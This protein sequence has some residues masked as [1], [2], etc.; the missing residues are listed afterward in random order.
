MTILQLIQKPQLRGA[1]MFACQLSNE[2]G[3]LGHKVLIVSLFPGESQ[4][5]INGIFIALNRPQNKRWNDIVGW[6]TLAKLIQEHHVDIV[7]CNAGDTLKFAVL[8]KKIYRWKTPIIARNASMVSSYISN[9]LTRGLNRWL[10]R[11][12]QAIA[13]VSEQSAL[14]LN[15]LFPETKPKITVIPIG[16]NFPVYE[17]V[18]WK[19]NTPGAYH[20]IHVGGFTFEKN[21]TGLLSIFEKLL[22]ASKTPQTEAEQKPPHYLLHL[23]GDGPLRPQIED[24]VR[25]KELE[26][27]VI[28]Y[29]FSSGVHNFIQK[30][31]MLLLPSIIEGLPGVI[32]EAFHAGTPVVAYNVGGIA[33]V[34][35][36]QTTGMLV[37]VGEEEKFVEAIQKLSNPE[38]TQYM[39]QQ[40]KNLVLKKFDN[41]YIAQS[42][43]QLY[44]NVKN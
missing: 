28:F 26:N 21:H 24:L 37:P 17:E 41:R 43:E 11:N 34:V 1:E 6:N 4:L 30:A 29:G 2:L 38:T 25:Q 10:Y 44:K 40:A 19:T 35:E 23:F 15:K 27:R 14:D 7:Q 22:Q 32:L 9:P 36:H 3:V 18:Q 16:V 12:T 31:D 20:L 42:F 8:S 33:E 5:P 13:S 39:T